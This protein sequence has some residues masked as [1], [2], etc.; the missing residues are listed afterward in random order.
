MKRLFPV[1]AKAVLFNS[2]KSKVLLI[3]M[4]RRDAWVLPGGHIDEGE[5]PDE[6]MVREIYEEC[7]VTSTDLRHVDFFMHSEGKIILAYVGT[8]REGELKS[9]QN[10]LEGVPK[11]I[12]KDE[13]DTLD[14]IEDVYRKVINENW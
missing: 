3:H 7:G 12:T 10:N 11:W 5:T 9:P 4:D 2:D 1:T 13:F 14:D 6:T 8:V